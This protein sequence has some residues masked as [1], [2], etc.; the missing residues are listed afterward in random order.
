MAR[1][2]RAVDEA[3]QDGEQPW[4][5]VDFVQDDETADVV[6]EVELGLGELR[7]VAP[8]LEV[9]IKCVVRPRLR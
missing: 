2:A 8:R 3:A 6:L 7:A 5:S 9:E 1:A 4:G